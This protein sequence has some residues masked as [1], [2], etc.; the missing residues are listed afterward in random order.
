M[1]VDSRACVLIAILLASSIGAC[2]ETVAPLPQ[3]LACPRLQGGNYVTSDG[4]TL[5]LSVWLPKGPVRAVLVAVHGM[6]D[7][8]LAWAPPAVAWM[9][10][11]IATYAYDQRGFGAAARRGTWYGAETLGADLVGLVRLVEERHPKAPVF[12]I[13]ESMGGAVAVLAATR[14]DAPPFDGV[15]LSAPAIW[16]SSPQAWLLLQFARAV[17]AVLPDTKVPPRGLLPAASDD[18]LVMQHLRNDP[19]VIHDT[20]LDTLAGVVDLMDLARRRGPSIRQPT[21]LLLGDD[22]VQ[23]YRDAIAQ[24]ADE[25]PDAVVA[26]YPSGPHLL[27]R[28]TRA[29]LPT[30]DVA[31]WILHPHSPLPSGNGLRGE[32]CRQYI[33]DPRACPAVNLAA[34]P[35]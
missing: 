16:D 19:L 29:A 7:Y 1:A 12:L 14:P 2:A 31:S 23:I 26:L 9:A 32:R 8:R 4:T 13:G 5:P 34:V 3:P 28:S 15:I 30:A 10:A 18:P 20:R 21:L 11:G 22:D 17:G 33:V 27:F 25:L 6:N 24:L 35:R